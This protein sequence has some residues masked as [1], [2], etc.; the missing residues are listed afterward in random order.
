MLNKI[1]RIPELRNRIL[2]TLF[3]ILV[4]RFLAHIPVPGVDIEAVRSYLSGSQ[5]FGL[6][7]LFSGGGFQNFSIVTLGVGPYINASIAFQL[8]TLM[9]PQLEELSKEGEYGREKISQYTR[10]ATVPL[11]LLQSYG[12]Y[13]LL[14]SQNVISSLASFDLIVLILTLTSGTLFLMWIGE[15]V[16][17]YGIGNG[18]SLLIFVGIITRLPSS[19]LQLFTNSSGE[20]ILTTLA[21][22]GF[23]ALVVYAIVLVNEGVRNIPLEY[24]RRSFSG[25]RSSGGNYLPIKI[26][27]AGVIPIIFA[28]SIVLI[29]SFVSGPLLAANSQLLQ[30]IGDFLA[31]NFQST[32]MGYNLLYFVLVFAFTFFYTFL[33]FNPEKVADDIRKR[34]G[35]IPGVRPGKSTHEYIKN[36]VLRLTLVGA[37][38]LGIVAVL[39]FIVQSITGLQTFAI[40]GTGILIV[41]SVVLETVRQ[42]EALLV[43]RNYE[44]FLE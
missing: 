38:F 40:G 14:R 11:A 17:E 37:L 25:P 4:F 35:F 36:V 43:T 22:L 15:Q 29:P 10:M 5:I 3:I 18:I 9:I 28:I 7:D 31:R 19:A 41:V 12:V 2:F 21:F 44:S 20:Q 34:G 42:V 8:L 16:T 30:S 27:Q 32:S 13:F 39:P 33:Q 6:F 24:G 1:F 23:S 26:N